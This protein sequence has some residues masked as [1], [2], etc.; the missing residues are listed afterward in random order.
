MGSITSETL[1]KIAWGLP[2]SH[3]FLVLAS[4][5]MV[6]GQSL[7]L[8]DFLND[9]LVLMV[10][11]YPPYCL[12]VSRFLDRVLVLNP[13]LALSVFTITY[14]RTL[15]VV[16]VGYVKSS[17]SA[18]KSA[19][20]DS[21]R[22]NVYLEHAAK[23]L[24]HDM[25]SGINIYIPRGVTSLERRLSKDPECVERLK[26]D[27]PMRMI[28]EGLNQ[29]R[30]VYAGVTEFTNLVRPGSYIHRSPQDLRAI[31]IEYLDS[32]SYKSDV[33]IA[34]LVTAEVNAPLFCTAIDNLIRNGLKYNDSALKMVT[35][36]MLDENTLA[37][38]DNGR[39]MDQNQFL[40]NS[41]PY[42]RRPDQRESGTGLGLNICVAILKEH[43]FTVSSY[44]RP[45]GGTTIKVGLK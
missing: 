26:L 12:N 8:L 24:R 25:N 27:V 9:T 33:M 40:E 19:L 35:V 13:N 39:G 32:T 3:R 34:E 20:E 6:V 43:G 11:G 17:E 28:R 1:L 18:I 23:I 5:L 31:L 22:K 21:N 7:Y 15:W 4:A 45:E 10:G 44:K 37:V 30:R 2:P 36:S 14:I 41:R 29:T 42:N 38:T 16:G